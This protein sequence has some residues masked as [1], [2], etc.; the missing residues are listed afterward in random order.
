MKFLNSTDYP[1]SQLR[2]IVTKAMAIAAR[3]LT[4]EIKLRQKGHRA[5]RWRSLGTIAGVEVAYSSKDI[6]SAKPFGY[7]HTARFGE[8]HYLEI[9]IPKAHSAATAQS[10]AATVVGAFETNLTFFKPAGET[11]MRVRAGILRQCAWARKMKLEPKEPKH[12]RT[13]KQRHKS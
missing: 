10:L 8:Q 12:D 2:A 3:K 5:Y 1:T 7:L 13:R 4:A 9:R 6:Y 11:A